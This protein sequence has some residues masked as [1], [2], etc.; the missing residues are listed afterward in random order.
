MVRRKFLFVL[1]Y[2][3]L[4]LVQN[5]DLLLFLFISSFSILFFFCRICRV[6]R[7][8]SIFFSLFIIIQLNFFPMNLKYK[9][10]FKICKKNW[11]S[12]RELLYCAKSFWMESFCICCCSNSKWKK[13]VSKQRKIVFEKICRMFKKLI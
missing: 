9:N 6:C 12:V 10:S 3:F 5:V 7:Y 1:L 8:N 2:F 4:I 11:S 13:N